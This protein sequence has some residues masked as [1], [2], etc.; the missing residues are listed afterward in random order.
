LAQRVTIKSIA[1]ELGISVASVSRALNGKGEVGPALEKR[2]LQKADELGYIA[3]YSARSLKH[4]KTNLIGVLVPDTFNPFFAHFVTK[5]EE[6]LY[7]SGYEILLST[8]RESLEKEREYLEIM[9]SKNVTGILAAPVDRTG[10]ISIYKRVKA[11]DIP[12]VFFDRNVEGLDLSRVN[13][14]NRSAVYKIVRYLYRKGHRR[15]A[16]VESVP[17]TSMGEERLAGYREA[18]KDFGLSE[19]FSLERFGLFIENDVKSQAAEILSHRPTA[20]ITG[21]LVITK[22]FLQ[23]LKTLRI[24]IPQELSLVSFDDIEWLE[25]TSPPITAFRQPIESLAMNAVALLK[26]EMKN[27]E[28]N[29]QI[30]VVEGELIIRNSVYDLSSEKQ[31]G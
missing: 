16:F 28:S 25:V 30:V 15:I 12:I 23:A 1:E 27:N 13:V 5:I 4:Q 3:N 18:I 6:L 9:V 29:S 24:K 26:R 10:N 20:L 17:N 22:A 31:G 8:T 19:E 21:N 2:I 7:D 11:M 14:D